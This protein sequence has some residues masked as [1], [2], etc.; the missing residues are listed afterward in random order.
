MFANR[1]AGPVYIFSAGNCFEVIWPTTPP[2]AANVV[3]IVAIWNWAYEGEVDQNVN[4][5][6]PI[7]DTDAAVTRREAPSRP[8]P[9]TGF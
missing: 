4:Q 7:V 2:N 1:T 8:K 9:A 3:D 6:G 5:L